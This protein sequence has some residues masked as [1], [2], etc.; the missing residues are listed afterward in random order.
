MTAAHC[1]LSSFELIGLQQALHSRLLRFADEK[2]LTVSLPSIVRSFSVFVGFPRGERDG[3]CS[4][5]LEWRG[6]GVWS[7][8]S[9]SKVVSCIHPLVLLRL[10]A[11]A[12]SR[13]Q[14]RNLSYKLSAGVFSSRVLLDNGTYFPS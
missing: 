11:K 8:N 7:K 4:C 3:I 14:L 5:R 13:L 6:Y 9:V 2:F 1:C 12:C 10:R